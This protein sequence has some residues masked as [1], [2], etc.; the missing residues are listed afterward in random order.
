MRLNIGIDL[1]RTIKGPTAE[2]YSEPF[3]NAFEVISKLTKIYNVYIV[4]RVNSEQRDRGIKWL[5]EKDFYNVTGVKK[6]NVYFCFDRRDKAVFAAG[7]KLDYF[8]D[9]RP[10]CLIPMEKRI[11]KILFNPSQ[12]DLEK[13]KEDLKEVKNLLYINN[14]LEIAQFFNILR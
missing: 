1:G 3:E 6:E 13:Y 4:S 10:G 12:F 9:D 11:I 5:E 7:L 8:I 14:W 2:K